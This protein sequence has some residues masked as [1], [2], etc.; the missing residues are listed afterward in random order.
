MSK[1]KGKRVLVV[2]FGVSGV[3]V[4]RFMSDQGAKVTV[5]DTKQRSEL[6]ASVQA[7]SDLKIEYELG[8]HNS[9]TFT[10][11]EL[12]V[13]SPGVPLD[14]KPLQEAREAQVQIMGD[15]DL[16]AMHMEIPLIAITGTNGKTTTTTL[17]GEMYKNAQKPAFVAGNIGKPICDYMN[18][19]IRAE[20]VVAELS[21]FQLDLTQRLV[22][23]VAV[24]T[25]IEEDHLDRYGTMDRYIL[26]KKRLLQ[27]CDKNSF[28]VLNYD[29]PL[30]RSFSHETPGKLLWFTKQDPIKVGGAFAESFVGCYYRRSNRSI[31]AKIFGKEE[32]FDVSKFKVPGEHNKENLMAAICAARAMGIPHS[33]IQTT[34]DQFRGVPHRLEF[35]R[36]KDGVFFFNDSKST[37]VHSVLQALAAFPQNPLIL[38]AGG[39]DKNSDFAPLVPYVQERVKILILLGEA[40]EKIN[41]AI[42]DYSE[43]YMVGTFEEAVLLAYQKSRSG[44]II[45]LSPGCASYDMFRNFEERGAYFTKLVQQL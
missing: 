18:E 40:K 23:A 42:G 31:V 19:S 12:I 15:V 5:T 11:S 25:N 3:S 34:I 39:K 26:A 38:I 9:K 43:T 4:A 33:A 35:V 37:N 13:V 16:A 36:K 41:R 45:L 32:I 7:C 27:L 21:S 44:D 10:S 20:A 30:L 28:V 29:N 8:K 24:F 14:M 17:V 1:F 2:G 22:P 6:Q